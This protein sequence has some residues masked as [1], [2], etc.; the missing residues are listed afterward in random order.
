MPYQGAG[1]ANGAMKTIS[2][3]QPRSDARHDVHSNHREPNGARERPHQSRN[4]RQSYQRYLE[5]AQ[6]EAQ[7]G[8]RI[9]AENYYQYAEHYFRSMSRDPETR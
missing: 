8:D 7:A 3:R 9:A 1:H 4:A 6:A 5:L 2:L